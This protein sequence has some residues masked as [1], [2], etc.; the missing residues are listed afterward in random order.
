MDILFIVFLAPYN[1][2][3]GRGRQGP[4]PAQNIIL[5]NGAIVPIG[6][7]I[8]HAQRDEQGNYIHYS[9]NYNEYIVYDISQV[10]M[11]YLV[12]VCISLKM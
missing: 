1:S 5:A 2:V 7:H 6:K 3:L 4:D 10:R 8:Q 9:L 12:Q 11:R